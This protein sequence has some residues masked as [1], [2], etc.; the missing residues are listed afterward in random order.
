MQKKPR[1]Y[2]PQ[3]NGKIERFHRTLADGWAYARFYASEAERR[4]ALPEWLHF[5][6]HHRPPQRDRQPATG[7]P[8]DQPPWTSQLSAQ[9]TRGISAEPIEGL[10][11]SSQIAS[12]SA[13]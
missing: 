10:C 7:Q 3:T 2:R 4:A 1:P 8:A 12:R 13:P 5:H 6:N 11:A 9:P